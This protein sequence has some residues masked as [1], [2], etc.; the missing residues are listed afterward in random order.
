MYAHTPSDR[1][2]RVSMKNLIT[3]HWIIC[4]AV[5]VSLWN[6]LA[7]TGPCLI[8][9]M[10]MNSI[11]IY[12]LFLSFFFVS[13]V[14]WVAT[15][16]RKVTSSNTGIFSSTTTSSATATWP[17]LTHRLWTASASCRYDL[18][19]LFIFNDDDDK[20]EPSS[21]LFCLFCC[22]YQPPDQKSGRPGTHTLRDLIFSLSL[23]HCLYTYTTHQSSIRFA[24][25]DVIRVP[26][27][28]F[29]S[30]SSSA[31]RHG[32]PFLFRLQWIDSDADLER[33]HPPET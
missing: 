15:R 20:R 24:W 14:Q 33:N 4:K 5:V 11:I 31:I 17:S 25:H 8:Q 21:S 22:S 3:Q 6:A 9:L 10:M 13:I 16:G 12:N 28:P 23:V 27:A 19:W 7:Q 26:L 2:N 30:L 1:S 29:L 18:Y 32:R